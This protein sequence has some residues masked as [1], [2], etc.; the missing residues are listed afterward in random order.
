MD[1][2]AS[3]YSAMF[4]IIVLSLMVVLIAVSAFNSVRRD[5]A[6]IRDG[7]QQRIIFENVPADEQLTTI[8]EGG[9]VLY[10][11][12]TDQEAERI[13]DEL[14]RKGATNEE[15]VEKIEPSLLP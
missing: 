5:S 1:K 8:P 15:R 6:R 9:E 3:T 14:L 2:D 13:L 10:E 4:A 7:V 11:G 12:L